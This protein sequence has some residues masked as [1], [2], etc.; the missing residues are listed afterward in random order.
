MVWYKASWIDPFFDALDAIAPDRA[1]GS[2]GTIGDDAHKLSR[3]GHNPDDTPGSLPEREDSD[4]KPEVRAADATSNLRRAGL[5]A[6]KIVA[7]ILAYLPDRDRLI[8]IICDGWIWSASNGWVGEPYDGD[9]PHDTHFHLSGH[10][11]HDDDGRPWLSILSLG[12]TMPLEQSDITKIW[13]AATPQPG[14]WE[15]PPPGWGAAPAGDPLPARSIL[16]GL[17]RRI[18][19]IYTG[20][21]AVFAQVQSN[22]TMLSALLS[23][24]ATLRTK[25]DGLSTP[26]V[27]MTEADRADIAH[28]V[29]VELGALRFVVAEPGDPDPAV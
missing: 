28:K 29:A 8:Y 21:V 10:P 5:T 11:D 7:A 13:D 24:V 23:G 1:T 14:N 3:S 26:T 27:S 22:G 4:S 19:L 16:G 18:Y 20:L 17:H 9:D 15:T 25:V 2:D 6:W 12:G